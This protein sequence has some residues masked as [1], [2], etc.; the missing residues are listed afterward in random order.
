MLYHRSFLKAMMTGPNVCLHES[1]IFLY[2]KVSD[3]VNMPFS[4]STGPVL[5]RCWQHRQHRPSTGPVLAHTGLFT[6]H[7][8]DEMEWQPIS[9]AVTMYPFTLLQCIPSS[10]GGNGSLHVIGIQYRPKISGIFYSTANLTT[11]S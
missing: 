7:I 4:A 11:L 10:H 1:Q 2:T 8:P 6:G 5:V 3:T 9:G